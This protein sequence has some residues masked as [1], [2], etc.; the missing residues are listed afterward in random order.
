MCVR[1]IAT[2]IINGFDKYIAIIYTIDK[3]EV[4]RL[5]QLVEH[6]SYKLGVVGSNPASPTKK[7]FFISVLLGSS[8]AEHTTVNRAVAGSNPARGANKKDIYNM[9][10]SITYIL[11]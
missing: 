9:L 10:C 2:K 6:Q 4:G 5:A 3:K 8:A 1:A 11:M 7:F